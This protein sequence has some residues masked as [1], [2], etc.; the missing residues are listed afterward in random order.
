MNNYKTIIA[1]A[2][3]VSE[4][5]EFEK[6]CF[7]H[8]ADRFPKRNLKHLIESPTSRTLIIRDENGQICAEIIGL[9]RH[10]KV[11][12]GRIYK[13]GVRPDMKK[14]GIGSYLIQT[15]EKWFKKSGMK[16]SCA[17]V[18]ESN[19]A[20]RNMFEKNGYTNTGLRIFYYAGGE[21]AVKYWKTL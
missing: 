13:I 16:K 12:S 1:D 11:A 2:K 5:F 14:R 18:R 19:M 20:S 8:T 10:F 4:L 21:N 3:I 6:I 15:I 7:E 17:E 9:I